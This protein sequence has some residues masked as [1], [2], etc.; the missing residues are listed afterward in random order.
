[1]TDRSRPTRPSR[2]SVLCAAVLAASLVVLVA[3]PAMAGKGG[4]GTIT[5]AD[6]TFAGTT[7]ATKTGSSIAWGHARCY[8]GGTL[9]Y[10]QYQKFGTGS[11]VTFTLGPTPLWTGGSASCYGDGGY[12][13]G[14]RFRVV[15]TDAFAVSG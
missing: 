1:M 15:A 9:V 8:Q 7:T 12:W 10:E 4:S 13:Q 5:V 3:A 11:T 6:G 2:S 14:S